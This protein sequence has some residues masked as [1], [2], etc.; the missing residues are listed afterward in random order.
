[1]PNMAAVTTA[2][3][4]SSYRVSGATYTVGQEIT[5]MMTTYVM[6]T[7]NSPRTALSQI[8]HRNEKSL[9]GRQ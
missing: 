2:I 1:M 6:Q 4:M 7:V 3:K 8:E 5:T 9:H